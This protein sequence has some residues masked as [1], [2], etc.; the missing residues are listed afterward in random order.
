M[1]IAT[2]PVT[3]A[4]STPPP[5]GLLAGETHDF[6][7]TV[8]PSGHTSESWSVVAGPGAFIDAATGI[9]QAPDPIGLTESTTVRVEVDADP[10]RVATIQVLLV[11]SGNPPPPPP[12]K[13]GVNVDRFGGAKI[14]Q[15]AGIQRFAWDGWNGA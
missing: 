13:G 6:D 11:A 1:I 15:L 7:V 3:V 9:F 4:I 2:D 8:S 12:V 14:D 10:S 5:L